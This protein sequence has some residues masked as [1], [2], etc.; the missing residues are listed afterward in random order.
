LNLKF[1]VPNP[2]SKI[3]RAVRIMIMLEP[4][5]SRTALIV[6][7]GTLAV[8]S[9]ACEQ[10][11]PPTVST[12]Q[13]TAAPIS[14]LATAQP[15]LR[16]VVPLAKAKPQPPPE[17]S[18]TE[19]SDF[20]MA[21]DKAAGA[22]TIIESAQ[23][24][25]DWSLVASQFQ[26]AIALMRKVERK[27]PNFAFAQGKIAE[28]QR[29][30]R[31]AQRK[32]SPPQLLVPLAQPHRVAVAIPKPLPTSDLTPTHSFARPLPPKP[33]SLRPL[34]PSLNEE[35]FIAPIRRRVGGTPVVEVIFNGRQRFEMIVDTGA[36]GTVITQQMANA[37]GIV[38]I[39][40]AKAN[41]ASSKSVEF[42]V[43]LVDSMAVGGLQVNR[44][45]VA[46]GGPELETG[47]LG[48]DFFGNFDVTIKR[49]VIEFRP[50]SSSELNSGGTESA[51]PTLPKDYHSAGSP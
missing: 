1:L 31:Y 14:N 2:K 8:L 44:V 21:L 37:L 45:P 48:H 42:P 39:G 19:P 9:A 32:A 22:W 41:T 30:V 33:V 17:E 3:A 15:T 38:P 40:K 12:G 34:V 50:Q 5:S 23:S 16:A 29:L 11:K 35:V 46:I 36:S 24:S 25:D 43:G 20:Q 51:P 7:S 18:E 6:L 4:F 27:S 13:Q 26:E 49:H 47:L 28:Y 10:N